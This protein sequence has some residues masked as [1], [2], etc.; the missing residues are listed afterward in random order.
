MCFHSRV[1]LTS[2]PE[3]RQQAAVVRE[4]QLRSYDDEESSSCASRGFAASQGELALV[5][6]ARLHV[7]VEV[8]HPLMMHAVLQQ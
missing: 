5:C 1:V 3:Q 2:Q 8:V 6:L 7:K 4:S